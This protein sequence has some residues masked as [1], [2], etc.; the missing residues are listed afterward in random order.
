MTTHGRKQ[1]NLLVVLISII[2]I[3]V[4]YNFTRVLYYSVRGFPACYASTRDAEKIYWRTFKSD[5]FAIDYPLNWKVEQ[6]TKKYE[7]YLFSDLPEGRMLFTRCIGHGQFG[8]D[9]LYS[10][11]QLGVAERFLQEVE[12]FRKGKEYILSPRNA[13]LGNV[14]NVWIAEW[15]DKEYRETRAL[16]RDEKNKRDVWIVFWWYTPGSH[17]GFEAI[18]KHVFDSFRF[19]ES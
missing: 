11:S 16:F 19:E 17:D 12:Q 14:A 3:V 1:I 10:S 7:E 9:R 18:K 2:V 13:Q 6:E 15:G 5:Y 4:G 8:I